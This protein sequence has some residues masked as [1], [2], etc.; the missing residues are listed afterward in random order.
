M[1]MTASDVARLTDALNAV[2]EREGVEKI[3]RYHAQKLGHDTAKRFRWD[4]LWAINAADR[5]PLMDDFY[6]YMDDTHIDTALRAYI[7][8]RPE[9]TQAPETEA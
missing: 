9:L 7:A 5:K 2:V 4:L 1:K 8:S 3:Q 6:V